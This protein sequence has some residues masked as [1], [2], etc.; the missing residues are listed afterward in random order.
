[1]SEF[2]PW[3]AIGGLLALSGFFSASETAMFSASDDDRTSMAPRARLLLREPRELLM[4]I[5]LGNLVINLFFFAVA[6]GAIQR[7]FELNTV[8]AGLIALILILVLGEIVPKTLALRAPFAIARV[9]AWPLGWVVRM[10]APARHSLARVLDLLLAAFGQTDRSDAGISSEVLAEVLD[11]SARDGLLA[12]GEADLLAEIVELGDLRVREIM[13]PRVD[14]IALDLQHDEEARRGTIDMAVKKRLTWLP[15]VD[16]GADEVRGCLELRDVL[17]HPER[18][19]EHAVMPVKFVPEVASV[20]KLLSTMRDDRVAEAVVVDEW[21][22]T[23]GIVTIEDIF[24]ELVGELR[25]EGEITANPV[26]PLGEGRFRVSGGLSIRDW[27]DRFGTRVVPTEF[28]T[29]G[30]FVTALHGRIPKAG[31]R[32]TLAGGLVC[33]VHEVR[34]RRVLTLDLFVADEQETRKGA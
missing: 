29:V 12:P 32:V 8:L 15:V 6:P 34:G 16:G 18:T 3:V 24:E 5:L 2:L 25:I 10:L 19:I 13:T 31:D 1:V 28:E 9:V 4:T 11:A 26:V 14:V 23:A 7:S 27:N 17:V 21:G 30:G 33:E 22:G 20:L